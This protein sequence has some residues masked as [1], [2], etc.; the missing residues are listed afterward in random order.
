M[1]AMPRTEAGRAADPA[2]ARVILEVA[3]GLEKLTASTNSATD[4]PTVS[5]SEDP[6]SAARDYV[7]KPYLD[8][9][10]FDFEKLCPDS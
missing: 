4:L 7:R 5:S 6:G 1:A 2:T 10:D 8:K 3:V 9:P